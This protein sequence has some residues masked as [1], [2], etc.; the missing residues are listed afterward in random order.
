MPSIRRILEVAVVGFAAV[1]SGLPGQPKLSS[2]A[3]NAYNL[4]AR[5]SAS[6]GLPS[7]LTDVDVLQLYASIP[8]LA[9]PL[10]TMLLS[11]LTLE[12]LETAFYQ[13]GFAKFQDSDFQAL[14]LS[15]QQLSDLKSIGATEQVHVTTLLSAIA[16]TGTQPVAPCQYNFGF[17]TAKDMVATASVLE[18]IGVSA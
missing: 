1:A 15:T 9:K 17:T 6:T 14:G 13:Q 3:V 16:G 18:N 2:R 8:S 5:Q 4:A 7:G 10:L 12:F 11:A